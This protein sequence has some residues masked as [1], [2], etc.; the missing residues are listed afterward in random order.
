M[1]LRLKLGNIAAVATLR[2]VVEKLAGDEGLSA[3]I[4][5]QDAV[6]SQRI[7]QAALY[8]A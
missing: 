2:R 4:L 7:V 3:A 6:K 8:G 1:P 5:R